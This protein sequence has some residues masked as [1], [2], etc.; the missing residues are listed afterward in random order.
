MIVAKYHNWRVEDAGRNGLNHKDSGEISAAYTVPRNCIQPHATKN[1]HFISRAH[2][3]FNFVLFIELFCACAIFENFHNLTA[4][5]FM[6]LDERAAFSKR[7]K[8]M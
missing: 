1:E 2:V 5:Y 7:R 4:K 8:T 3:G 6:F